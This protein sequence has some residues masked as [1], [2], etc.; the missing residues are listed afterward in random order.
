[1]PSAIPTPSGGVRAATPSGGVRAAIGGVSAAGV[2]LGVGELAAGLIGPESSPVLAVGAAA[3]DVSPRATTEFAISTFGSNDK[4]ALLIGM[5]LVLAVAAA[6]LGVLAV[7]RLG[8]GVAGMVVLGVVGAAAAV[9]RP[10]ASVLAAVPSLLAAAAGVGALLLMLRMLPAGRDDPA[11]S[12]VPP[13]LPAP[14]EIER[15][16]FVLAAGAAAGVAVVTTGAG[17]LVRRSRDV[18]QAREQLLVP[19]AA[20][21]GLGSDALPAGFPDLAGLSPLLT[22]NDD[23]YR[24]DTALRVPQ[25]D[26]SNWSLRIHGRVERELRFT[27]AELAGRDDLIE[28]DITLACVSNE[29]GGPLAGSARWVGVPLATLLAEA[30]VEPGADQVLTRSVDGWTCGTPTVDCQRTPNAML[31]LAM[32]GENLPLEHGFPV[33]MIVPGLYGYVSATKWLVDMELTTFAGSDAYWVR[34]GWD[35]T[36][37]IQTFS[38]IDVP[39]PGRTLG[40]GMAAIAGVAH[41]G[42]DG[43][44]AVEVRIDD[45]PWEQARM[46]ATTSTQLWRQW[47]HPWVAELGLHVISVRAVDGKGRTQSSSRYPPYPNASSGWHSVRVVVG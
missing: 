17:A 41:S 27:F 18:A 40:A 1:M 24:I 37:P 43:V 34:R 4:L 32:N 23:F 44:S 33:R 28:A 14:R 15:R 45:Q 2:A 31:A 6:L 26:P 16:R 25:I 36:A 9:S 46:S 20:T 13:E 19:A 7:R 35:A 39:R 5:L 10:G 22:P 12:G 30:G 29:V 38:R 8:I 47:Y 11:D 21:P 3:V 42:S